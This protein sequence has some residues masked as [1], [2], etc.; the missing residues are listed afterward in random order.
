[1]L[2][3]DIVGKFDDDIARLELDG[4]HLGGIGKGGR[5]Q[6]EGQGRGDEQAGRTHG[7]SIQVRRPGFSHRRQSFDTPP[8]AWHR[9]DEGR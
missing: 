2:R 7:G 5:G 8:W 9:H 3:R 4:Q 1:V 6:A